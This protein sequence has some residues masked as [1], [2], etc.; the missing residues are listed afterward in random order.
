MKSASKEFGNGTFAS[1]ALSPELH[2]VLAAQ[3]A[4]AP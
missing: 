3:L 2:T 1:A 4:A